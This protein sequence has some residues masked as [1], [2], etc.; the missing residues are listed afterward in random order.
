MIKAGDW[1]Q[2]HELATSRRYASET[3]PPDLCP[4]GQRGDQA[5]RA[6]PAVRGEAA[7]RQADGDRRAYRPELLD[8]W[9]DPA[10]R[11]PGPAGQ[12]GPRRSST[13]SPRPSSPTRRAGR[14]SPLWDRRG[15]ELQGIRRGGRVPDQGRD[16]AEAD[17]GG[18]AARPGGRER[19]PGAGDRRGLAGDR[20][21]GRPPRRRAAPRPRRD[22]RRR[23]RR[24]MRSPPCPHGEDEAADL[25]LLKAWNAGIN[26]SDGCAEA[27]PFRAR[28]RAARATGRAS[29]RIEEAD[30]E[31]DQGRAP[32]RRSS[33]RPR[34]SRPAT[35]QVRRPD[36]PGPRA[37]GLVAALDQALA[38]SR[39]LPTWRSPPP[40][41]AP[42]PTAPGPPDRRS[43]P[44]ASWRSAA[45]TCSA[46]STRSPPPCRSTSRMPSG[47]P[48]GTMPCWPTAT[49]PASIASATS[50]P[51]RGSRRSPSWNRRWT[52]AT[53][54]RSSGCARD[55]ILADHP[56][57]AR[58]TGRDRCPDRQER[59][60]R[61][62]GRRGARRPGRGVPRRGRARPARRRTPPS[63][64]PTATGSPRGSTGGSSGATSSARPTR[65]S[66]PTP[67]ERPSPRAGPGR[68]RGSS[69]SAWSPP[70]HGGS[71]IAPRRPRR[72]T[73]N[74]DPETHRRQGGDHLRAAARVP[75]AV[76]HRLARG[77]P[78]LGP[79]DR[80]AVSDRA[81]SRS[82]GRTRIR[83]ALDGC[84]GRPVPAFRTGS[85]ISSTGK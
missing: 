3:F 15:R 69:G 17:R 73:V 83:R 63:S 58:R 35:A 70:T 43:P 23:S 29:E 36:P 78:R 71:S 24:S 34:P 65:C 67:A 49:T 28:V 2:I 41:S 74:L 31:A 79:A 32:S 19:G 62:A 85:S 50:R 80:P 20:H 18:G 11:G 57:L 39:P 13:S 26:R 22:G 27:D 76:R 40:P 16:L 25:A 51:S 77:G 44:A 30:R 61:A 66:S 53:P 59:A 10:M 56:G 4:E 9:L 46:S 82:A 45:A 75:E 64:P 60:G 8:D 33:T 84:P 7:R 6:R 38:A 21:A 52:A 47:P 48:P 68:S 54:S 42:A 1:R 55:P 12:G 72:G 5:G 81:L 37:A 14:W